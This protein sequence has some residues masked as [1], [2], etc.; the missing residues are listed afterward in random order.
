MRKR[1]LILIAIIFGT[2]LLSF[3]LVFLRHRL[4]EAQNSG[5]EFIFSKEDYVFGLLFSTFLL[6]IPA[7]ILG[8]ISWLLFKKKHADK[9]FHFVI[10]NL[11]S[12]TLLL[13]ANSNEIHKIW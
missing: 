7:F 8:I 3:S 9:T 11:I 13:I 2:L 5:V 12:L 10:F 1:L 6:I 4:E